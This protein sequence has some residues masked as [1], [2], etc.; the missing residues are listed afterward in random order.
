MVTYIVCKYAEELNWHHAQPR[1]LKFYMHEVYTLLNH[2]G[3]GSNF[4]WGGGGGG[5]RTCV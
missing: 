1:E 2:I 3:V 4:I 5:G